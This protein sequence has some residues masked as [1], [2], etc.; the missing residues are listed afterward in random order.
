MF[1]WLGGLRTP[2]RVT[3]HAALASGLARRRL[4]PPARWRFAL[5]V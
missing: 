2:N 3:C 5:Q 1:L 4:R